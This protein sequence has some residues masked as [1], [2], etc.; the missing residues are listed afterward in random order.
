VEKLLKAG[1]LEN[2]IMVSSDKGT[3]QGGVISP[4]ISNLVLRSILDK[5]LTITPKKYFGKN[6]ISITLTTYADDLV[7]TISPN[8]PEQINQTIWQSEVSQKV[9]EWLKP[10]LSIAGLELKESKTRIITDDKPFDFLG[11]EIQRGKGIRLS[12]NMV[13]KLR[14]KVKAQLQRGRWQPRVLKAINPI[15]RGVYNYAAKFSSGKM[16]RP[17]KTIDFD[18]G[19]RLFKLYKTYDIGPVRFTDVPKTTKYLSPPKGA[20]WLV[21][22]EYWDKRNLTGLSPRKQTLFQKPHGICPH[23]K[24][25]LTLNDNEVLETHHLISKGTGGKDNHSNVILTHSQCHK[26]IHQ[27]ETESKFE[28][29]QHHLTWR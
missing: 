13:K 4:T 7:I 15:L 16:W 29:L 25:K 10:Q 11:S 9:I 22:K 12:D 19:K 17:L 14:T 6:L 5:P 2:E 24:G 27:L 23:C 28:K 20:T 26:Q 3:P 8:H 18:I 21:N 1:H